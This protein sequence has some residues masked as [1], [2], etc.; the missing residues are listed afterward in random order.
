MQSAGK[1]LEGRPGDL[2]DLAPAYRDGARGRGGLSGL[3]R[4]A[5]ADQAGAAC[6]LWLVEPQPQPLWAL[7]RRPLQGQRVGVRPESSGP[8]AFD[9]GLLPVDELVDLGHAETYDEVSV[10]SAQIGHHLAGAHSSRTARCQ[11]TCRDAPKGEAGRFSL[12]SIHRWIRRSAKQST[13]TFRQHRMHES[14]EFS[15]VL[16]TLRTRRTPV[17]PR[18]NL[19]TSRAG[20]PWTMRQLPS[21]LSIGRG[22]LAHRGLLVDRGLVAEHGAAEAVR[23]TR[24]IESHQNEGRQAE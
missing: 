2:E 23:E 14:H 12:C 9:P 18:G 16:R 3:D 11:L 13:L 5:N 4:V 8:R 6:E 7:G 15:D 22:L 20:V 17:L 19:Q 1:R 10:V 21:A 24:Q